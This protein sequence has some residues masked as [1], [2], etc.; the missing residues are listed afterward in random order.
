MQPKDMIPPLPFPIKTKISVTTMFNSMQIIQRCMLWNTH[1]NSVSEK[2]INKQSSTDK[3]YRPDH[4]ENIKK[5]LPMV[6]TVVTTS[7]SFSL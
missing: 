7:S 6:G 3:V 4:Q 1:G 5:T 2:V